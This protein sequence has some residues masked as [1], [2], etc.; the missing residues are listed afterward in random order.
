MFPRDLPRIAPLVDILR[1]PA[2]CNSRALSN[3]SI[4]GED[5]PEGVCCDFVVGQGPLGAGLEG[6][7]IASSRR[8][9]R[10]DRAQDRVDIFGTS[11][12]FHVDICTD[13]LTIPVALQK[14]KDLRS[15]RNAASTRLT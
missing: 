11:A 3:T 4:D 6:A 2:D 8:V 14:A 1:V 9:K 5:S 10:M 13:I 15:L 12:V 7:I